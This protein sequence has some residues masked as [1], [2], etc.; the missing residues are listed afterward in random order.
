MKRAISVASVTSK[1]S[2]ALAAKSSASC[3]MFCSMSVSPIT[4]FPSSIYP[5]EWNADRSYKLL[6]ILSH[7]HTRP[8]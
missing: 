6:M 3:C 2:S 7:P 1:E 4:A 5:D 8:A